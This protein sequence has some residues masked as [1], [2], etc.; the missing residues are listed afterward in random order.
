MTV[1]FFFQQAHDPLICYRWYQKPII[2]STVKYHLFYSE[3][4]VFSN[5]R[6]KIAN[7]LSAKKAMVRYPMSK[8]ALLITRS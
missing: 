4:I 8:H 3:C 2:S 6:N 5:D 7:E 1:A